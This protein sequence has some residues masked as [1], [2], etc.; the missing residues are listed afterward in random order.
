V[1]EQAASG[2]HLA[3]EIIAKLR[4]ALVNGVAAE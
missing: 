3:A 1:L 4:G 2:E